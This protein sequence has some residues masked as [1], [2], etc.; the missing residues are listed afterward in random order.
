MVQGIE[1]YEKKEK[2]TTLTGMIEAHPEYKLIVNSNNLTMEI[3]NEIN[4]IHKFCRLAEKSHSWAF[5]ILYLQFLN[6]TLF[7]ACFY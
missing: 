4:I 1:E 6:I 2:Q 5:N 7:T 3:D